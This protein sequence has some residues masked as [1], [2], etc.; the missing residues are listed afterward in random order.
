MSYEDI[1]YEG[2]IGRREKKMQVSRKWT[3]FAIFEQQNEADGEAERKWEEMRSELQWDPGPCGVLCT[4]V[5]T[6]DFA[7]STK[8]STAGCCGC[9]HESHMDLSKSPCKAKFCPTSGPLPR[10]CLLPGMSSPVSAEPFPIPLNA[11]SRGSWSW[12]SQID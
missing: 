2:V 5:R 4:R 3:R 12:P 6:W 7:V 9:N 10:L 11:V 8:G 1:L